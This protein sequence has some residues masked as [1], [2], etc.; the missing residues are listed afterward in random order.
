MPTVN[1]DALELSP[2]DSRYWNDELSND[3]GSPTLSNSSSSSVMPTSPSSTSS[4][5]SE[6]SVGSA[7]ESSPPPQA[8]RGVSKD[9]ARSRTR[10]P[11]RMASNFELSDEQPDLLPIRKL[12]NKGDTYE[13]LFGPEA[14]RYMVNRRSVS[15]APAP[16]NQR[17]RK[18]LP[19]NPL[20]GEQLGSRGGLNIPP[21]DVVMAVP[22][23]SRFKRPPP[24]GYTTQL[25]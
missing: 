3:R 14:P 10:K 22:N 8:A 5:P 24:G 19:I 11:Y 4:T 9:R 21:P 6:T 13:A 18:P 17:R 20:T 25:W 7:H 1:V 12:R 2:E 23:F 16:T 15:A